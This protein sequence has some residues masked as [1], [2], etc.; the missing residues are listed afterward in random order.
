[1]TLPILLEEKREVTPGAVWR[2]LKARSLETVSKFPRWMSSTFQFRCWRVLMNRARY[3]G[4]PKMSFETA[5]RSVRA[6]PCSRRRKSADFLLF[7]FEMS[8][9]QRFAFALAW[10]VKSAVCYLTGLFH[11]VALLVAP[12]SLLLLRLPAPPR[13]HCSLFQHI[14]YFLL[15]FSP[16]W[17]TFFLQTAGAPV[18]AGG[19]T[20][21]PGRVGG[22]APLFFEN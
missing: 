12:F 14:Q 11:R 1:M 21:A 2:D 16:A 10:P 9:F 15:L 17:C 5:A 22:V 4:S 20:S 8:A 3:H 13:S 18:R 19:G 7:A 6:A